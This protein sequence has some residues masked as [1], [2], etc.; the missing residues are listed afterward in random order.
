MYKR[1]KKKK[2]I[3]FNKKIEI[4]VYIFAENTVVV[5][6]LA[7]WKNDLNK[8][9]TLRE[10]KSVTFFEWKLE[11]EAKKVIQWSI[12]ND[13]GVRLYFWLNHPVFGFCFF[14]G[15]RTHPPH[16]IENRIL[17]HH[18]NCFWLNLSRIL[19]THSIHVCTAY[20]M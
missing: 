10:L 18:S 4:C 11:T 19:F 2:K 17:F 6:V 13:V 8:K 9:I 16:P 3:L 1:R 7:K 14:V 15:R 20:K 12:K 5:D